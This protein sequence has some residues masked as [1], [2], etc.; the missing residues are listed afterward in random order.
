MLYAI[1]MVKNEQDTIGHVVEHLLAEGIDH[2]I[3]A[4]NLSTDRTRAVL[5]DLVA[6]GW[7]VTVVEDREVAYLQ[8]VKMNRLV[9]MARDAGA[10]WVVPFDADE[11]WVS[12][13]PGKR[14]SDVL[15]ESDDADVLV[16][17][18]HD[19]VPALAPA[20]GRTCF[21]R[22]PRRDVHASPFPK[23]AFRPLPRA[24]ITQGNHYV[25]G[26][27]DLRQAPGRFMVHHFRWQSVNHFVA[28]NR[29]GLAAYQAGGARL[30]KDWGREWRK[31]GARSRPHLILNYLNLIRFQLQRGT[32]RDNVLPRRLPL[33]GPLDARTPRR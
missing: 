7:P 31:Y 13:D 16:G 27:D 12:V 23:V 22:M 11:L 10:T 19:H 17:D 21:Q 2:V 24:A 3:V 18:W 26:R 1:T 9:D 29:N 32:V 4:D 5:D 28:K 8:A 15:L 30:D 14:L 6:R 33:Q 25:E 20:F